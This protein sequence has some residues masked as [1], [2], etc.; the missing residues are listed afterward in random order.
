MKSRES[1]GSAGAP[2]SAASLGR[3]PGA[4]SLA[5]ASPRRR[6]DG[7]RCR[8]EMRA[9]RRARRGARAFGLVEQALGAPGRGRG[10]LGRRRNWGAMGRSATACPEAR[11]RRRRW[12]RP[13]RQSRCPRA[14]A[15]WSP[16]CA[17]SRAWAVGGR[18]WRRRRGNLRSR[19]T[20][21]RARADGFVGIHL[22]HR[23]R[24]Q[25]VRRGRGDGGVAR[26]DIVERVIA[27]VALVVDQIK[28][29]VV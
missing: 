20:P 29:D 14:E 15:R 1:R 11:D 23:F 24:R 18:A 6:V 2:R 21:V 7:E 27:L 13:R 22:A 26:K 3:L 17:A 5:P 25:M 19:W 28:L 4:T 10:Q 16:A 12:A 8:R 9:A